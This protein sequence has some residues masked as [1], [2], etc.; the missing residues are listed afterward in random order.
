MSLNGTDTAFH[1]S[2]H[3]FAL[4]RRIPYRDLFFLTDLHDFLRQLSADIGIELIIHL[5]KEF[6]IRRIRR[7]SDDIADILYY[8]MRKKCQLRIS[9]P[10]GDSLSLQQVDQ[11]QCT[12]MLPVENCRF[13][14]TSFCHLCQIGILRFSGSY[15]YLFDL[16]HAF[17]GCTH[18]LFMAQGVFL[19]KMICRRHDICI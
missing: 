3:P 4:L 2:I 8:S 12:F 18:M 19:Y 15:R 7:K 1:I 6:C 10:I 9:H 17:S 13:C 11:R 14:G 16:L 5:Q